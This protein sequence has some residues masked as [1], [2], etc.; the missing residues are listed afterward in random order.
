VGGALL[1][2]LDGVLVD[3]RRPIA[4]SINFALERHG[5]KP[6]PQARLYRFIGAPLRDVFVELL[7]A[8]EA[9]AS[10]A[11]SCIEAYRVRYRDL[12]QSETQLVAGMARALEHLRALAPLAVAT[13][14]PVEFARPILERVGVLGCFETVVGPPLDGS[15]AKAQ[16]VERALAALGFCGLAKRVVLVGD[17][18]FDVEAARV[19]ELT[20]VGVTWGI[21]SV[22][23]L[24]EAGVDHLVE[25]PAELVA[26]VESLE[27]EPLGGAQNSRRSRRRD[28]TSR[29][30]PL[31]TSLGSVPARKGWK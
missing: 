5:L 29:S 26:L 21:G 22:R 15:E 28:S 30:A 16:T 2:D 19:H 25:T 8:R 13:S 7:Q 27:R 12:S 23:E 10:L 31:A 17:T 18:R 4:R 3:S 24:R 11:E 1:F 6:S 20:A 14:K 9:P